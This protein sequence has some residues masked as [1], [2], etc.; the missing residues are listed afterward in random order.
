MVEPGHPEIS[1]RCQ[2]ELLGVNRPGLYYR[3]AEES[4]ENLR[5]DAV[6]R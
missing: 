6:D 4:Q 2:C 1:V 3:P 5:L